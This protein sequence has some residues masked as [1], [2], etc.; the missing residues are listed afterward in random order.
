MPRSGARHRRRATPTWRWCTT[1]CTSTACVGSAS[2]VGA[3]STPT[4]WCRSGSFATARRAAGGVLGLDRRAAGGR[5]RRRVRRRPAPRASR[6]ARPG[7]GVLPV[8]QRRRSAPPHWPAGGER[9]AI[10]DWDVHHGNGT[11]DIFYDDPRVLYVSTHQS[12]LYPG[13]GR[14]AETGGSQAPGTTL[15][16]PFPAGTR[17]RRVPGRV[18]RGDRAGGRVVRARL[19][20]HLRRLRRPPRRS[21]GRAR[22]DQS[23]DYAD[24]ARRLAALVRR[25][26][27][28]SCSRAATTSTPSPTRSER[29]SVLWSASTT[30][31]NRRR[32]ATWAARPS[33]PPANSGS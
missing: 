19:A 1:T 32:R 20:D 7:D 5:V 25:D 24:F 16:L 15:N 6:P 28:S 18:R 21:A 27:C 8:Q 13:T 14:L 26:A 10:V 29:R 31:P 3:T 30:D 11:Q 9:V 33:S 17:R 22:A 2:A 12:P 4:R 23:A